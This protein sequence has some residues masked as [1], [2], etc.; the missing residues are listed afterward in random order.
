MDIKDEQIEI[1]VA[2]IISDSKVDVKTPTEK[3]TIDENVMMTTDSDS[4]F[5][6]GIAIGITIGI[7]I[8]LVSIFIIRQKPPK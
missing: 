7:A 6:T 1:Q 4:S 3:E 5:S 8:G 2:P